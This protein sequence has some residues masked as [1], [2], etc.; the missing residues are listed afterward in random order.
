MIRPASN[1]EAINICVQQF[2][3]VLTVLVIVI[4]RNCN[5]DVW[6]RIFIRLHVKHTH[7]ECDTDV[8]VDCANN[9]PECACTQ[10]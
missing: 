10:Q 2:G 3:I 4:G 9:V 5:K 1:C 6:M 8:L 7:N